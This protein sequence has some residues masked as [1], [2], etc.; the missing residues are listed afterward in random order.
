[1]GKA[2]EVDG[3]TSPPRISLVFFLSRLHFSPGPLATG[4]SSN[5][6][7]YILVSITVF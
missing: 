1:M 6:K 3:T 5:I 4:Q 2:G 7:I